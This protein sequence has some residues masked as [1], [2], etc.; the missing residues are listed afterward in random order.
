M[1]KTFEPWAEEF[2]WAVAICKPLGCTVEKSK[3]M[4]E[5]ATVKGDGVSLV[6]YPHRTTA[7]NYHLRVRDNSSKDR[8]KA[9]AVMR[10]L[11]HGE[12]LPKEIADRIRFSCTFQSK[13]KINLASA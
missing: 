2:G 11:D 13:T 8:A 6:I 10:A 12:G 7:G 5:L 1:S 9:A 3:A 4:F